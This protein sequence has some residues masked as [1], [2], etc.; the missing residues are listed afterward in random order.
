M[1]SSSSSSLLYMI[2]LLLV[3]I[4]S[5]I[6]SGFPNDVFTSLSKQISEVQDHINFYAKPLVTSYRYLEIITDVSCLKR[7]RSET[8]PKYFFIE[9]QSKGR[10]MT[11]DLP[12]S[13][14]AK[15]RNS[16]YTLI[17]SQR[18]AIF[19]INVLAMKFTLFSNVAKL[20]KTRYLD[21]K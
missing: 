16:L 19:F 2:A 8:F 21:N 7:S 12:N 17:Q 11:C 13:I 14:S 18:K 4:H 5:S 1:S 3:L 6:Q 20:N 9:L 15:D 10:H